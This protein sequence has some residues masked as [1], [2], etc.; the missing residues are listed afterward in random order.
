M[1]VHYAACIHYKQSQTLNTDKSVTYSVTNESKANVTPAILL[2]DKITNVTWRAMQ[3][4]TV[5]SNTALF[6]FVQLCRAIK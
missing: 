5:I 4:F 6:Y 2:F 1:R 3:L